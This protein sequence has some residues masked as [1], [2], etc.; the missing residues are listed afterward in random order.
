HGATV[1]ASADELIGLI[2]GAAEPL[3]LRHAA[4]VAELDRRAAQFGERRG[5]R[6]EVE[7]RHKR[8]LRRYRTDELK[9]GLVALAGTYR[10]RL[11]EGTLHDPAAGVDAV[12]SVHEAIEALERNLNEPL[13]LE[14]LLLR[15]PP[16]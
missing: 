16:V 12:R 5:D 4:E 8:E 10:D 13:L 11:A 3:K 7:D 2:D 15:L 1:M 6:K 9:S 14:A